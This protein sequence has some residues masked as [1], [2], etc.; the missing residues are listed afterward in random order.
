MTALLGLLFIVGMFVFALALAISVG[1][2]QT[3]QQI[4]SFAGGCLYSGF[5]TVFS[6]VLFL[7]PISK[8]RSRPN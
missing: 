2:T 1:R 7:E 5:I 6:L 4:A 3:P 8:L